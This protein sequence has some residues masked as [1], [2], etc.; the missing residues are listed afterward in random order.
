MKEKLFRFLPLLFIVLLVAVFIKPYIFEGKVPLPTSYLVTWSS[1]WKYY[2]TMPVKN[3]MPD[4]VGQ[5]YPWKKIT[6]NSY[7][8]YQLPLWNPYS[9]SGTPHLA[10]FQSAV[11]SPF[12]ILY[13]LM[14][15]IDAWSILIFLQ[16]ILAAFFT[17]ILCRKLG[18]SQ[19]GSTMSAV[20]FGFCGFLTVWLGYGTLGYA[21][22]FLP[23]ALFAVESIFEGRGGLYFLLL[24]LTVPLSFFSGHFQTSLYFLLGVFVYS[25]GRFL[26]QSEKRNFGKFFSIFFVLLIGVGFSSL[27]LFPSLELFLQSTR[28][29]SVSFEFFRDGLIPLRY[30]ITLIFPDFYGNPV[31]RNDWFGK[32]AEWSSYVGILPLFLSLFSIIKLKKREVPILIIGIIGFLLAFDTPVAYVMHYLSVPVLGSSAA[33]RTVVLLSF[34]LAVLSGFGM[35]KIIES[36]RLVKAVFVSG[37]GFVLLVFG[38]LLGLKFS[39]SL[40]VNLA[41]SLRNIFFPAAIFMIGFLPLFFIGKI[42]SRRN[43][44]LIFILL[45]T[46]VDMLRFATKWQ[47]F[48]DKDYLY[49]DNGVIN[50]LK[51]KSSS[52]RVVG[53]LGQ[54]V[55]NYFGLYG[56]GGYD[57]L[58][59][60]RYGDFLAA[61][62]D[63]IMVQQNRST[64]SL[65]SRGKYTRKY[66]NLLGAKYLVV[67]RSSIGS[68]FV[69]PIWETNENEFKK[70]YEDDKHQIFENK[71]VIPRTFMVFDYK[72][73]KDDNKIF[74][75]MM[76]DKFDPLKEAVLEED[77]RMVRQKG[78]SG[79]AAIY[80]YGF[81]DVEIITDSNTDGILVLSDVYAP[82]WMAMVDET[83][84]TVMRGDFAFRAVR[85]P[86][87]FH[88]VKFFYEPKSLEWG[89]RVAL[90]SLLVLVSFSVMSIAFMRRNN[91]I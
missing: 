72:T 65:E 75:Y 88:K 61:A 12:N 24:G 43:I 64:A 58:N 77:P 80:K 90:I 14:P 56:V 51:T 59:I 81:N 49:P 42:K 38:I 34:S 15:M 25:F 79:S 68:E 87:G 2:Y 3:G 60:A 63:G 70:V 30:L 89:I 76:S 9:F 18:I 27:Q 29:K 40:S 8:D 67:D 19:K 46:S 48:D 85:V 31:T 50:F 91:F 86:A 44:V 17:Y 20:S 1:P 47:P 41:I 78:A 53:S 74:T 13:F 55:T 32:Y 26:M 62:Q 5:I 33:S 45:L 22:L 57:P 10:N 83:P 28:S 16:I 84:V 35:D 23:L 37:A 4:V 6:I 82:G 7:S 71:Q 21:I 39:G 36:S 69:F 73:E 66:Y 54:D 11:F 52:Y